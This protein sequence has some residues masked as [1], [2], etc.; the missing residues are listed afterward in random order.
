MKKTVAPPRPLGQFDLLG[1]P[2]SEM[3]RKRV[4]KLAQKRRGTRWL[5]ELLGVSR[6]RASKLLNQGRVLGAVRDLRSGEWDLSGCIGQV[7]AG[8]RGPHLR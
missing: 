7:R 4:A 8:R 5:A 1:G 2:N 3:W 6:Q